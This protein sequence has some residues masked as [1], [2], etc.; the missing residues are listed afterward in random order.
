M[1]SSVEAMTPDDRA[2]LE[3]VA[4][5]V[6]ELHMEVPA[7]LALETGRPLSVLA[8]QTMHFFEPL[9]TTL[10]PIVDYRRLARLVEQRNAIEELIHAIES[11]ADA[12]H[13]ERRAGAAARRDARREEAA[14]RADTHRTR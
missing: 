4:T 3:R 13:A 14:R 11:R 10:L 1:A 9:A 5:R 7:I 2:L 6:V 8:G 12:A